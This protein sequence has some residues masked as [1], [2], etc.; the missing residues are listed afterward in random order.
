M[1]SPAA[2]QS[3][4]TRLTTD[5]AA[6]LTAAERLAGL[7]AAH[8]QAVGE[9]TTRIALALKDRDDVSLDELAIA[10]TFARLGRATAD[11]LAAELGLEIGDTADLEVVLRLL[12]VLELAYP[13]DS[14]DGPVWSIRR[15]R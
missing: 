6:E 11:E 8:A 7:Q 14:P 5:Q 2:R 10:L 4:A 1:T 3:R 9:N 13:F 12:E 15:G